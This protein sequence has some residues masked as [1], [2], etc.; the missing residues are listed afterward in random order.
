MT[1]YVS[2]DDINPVEDILI[3]VRS[4]AEYNAAHIPGSYNIPISK[5]D[6][7][8][9]DLRHVT[10]AVLLCRT[11]NRSSQAWATLKGVGADVSVLKNGI[12][13]WQE[14]G[15]DMVFGDTATWSMQRQVQFTAGTIILL[16]TVLGAL[17]SPWLYLIAGFIGAGLTFAGATGTC[18]LARL[19]SHAPWNEAADDT[20]DHVADLKARI[21]DKH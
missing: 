21:A 19:L 2:P 4:P 3:D 16:S 14:S 17:A 10:D 12:N 7:H 1:R 11:D 9:S 6:D 5:L 20:A 13:A 18:G 15:R 8:Q